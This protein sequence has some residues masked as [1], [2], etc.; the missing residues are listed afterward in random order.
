MYIYIYLSIYLS[1]FI[2]IYLMVEVA[3]HSSA[4]PDNL[5]PPSDPRC[6][7]L[8]ASSPGLRYPLHNRPC[9]LTSHPDT[10]P[11]NESPLPEHGGTGLDGRASLPQRS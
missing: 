7:V 4:C 5:T 9:A 1:V 3:Q 11:D 10:T 2:S 8:H 6:P